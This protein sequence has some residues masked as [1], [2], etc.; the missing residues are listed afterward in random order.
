MAA[1]RVPTSALD[2]RPTLAELTRCVDVGTRW[3]SLGVQLML[4]PRL[5]DAIDYEKSR[6]ED[7]LSAMFSL[8][9]QRNPKGSRNDILIALRNIKENAIAEEYEKLCK[10][11]KL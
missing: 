3:H 8:W 1:R 7:K 10:E 9:L 4:E 11:G 2:E 5:L 6:V